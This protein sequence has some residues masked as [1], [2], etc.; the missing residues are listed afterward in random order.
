MHADVT[1]AARDGEPA[2]GRDP[3]AGV[4][5]RAPAA[6]LRERYRKEGARLDN[7]VARLEGKL[8]NSQFTSKASPDVVA[9]EREKLAGYE[10][11]R[12]RVRALLAGLNG[13]R[14]GG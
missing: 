8:G 1:D 6:L 4:T 12:A 2:M 5:V 13:T 10:A 11:A 3:L 9:K 14:N 7:E